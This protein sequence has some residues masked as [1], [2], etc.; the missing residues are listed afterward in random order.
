MN[1]GF[2][3]ASQGLFESQKAMDITSNNVANIQTNGFKPL[4]PSFSDL[5]YTVRNPEKENVEVGHGTKIGKTDLMFDKGTLVNTNRTL[6]F[7]ISGEQLFAV[8]APNGDV[9][10]T[11]D[12][13]FYLSEGADTMYIVDAEGN[14]VLDAELNPVS[15]QY[16]EADEVDYAATN[17]LIGAFL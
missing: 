12:G 11:K 1:I 10:Y 6:D 9:K 13:A 5:M 17:A 14:F 4:R 3:T 2:Y 16:N 8:Q 7:A 15:L